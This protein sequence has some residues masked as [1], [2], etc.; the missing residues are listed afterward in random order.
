M[1]LLDVLSRKLQD[2][3]YKYQNLGLVVAHFDHGIRYESGEDYELVKQIAEKHGLE[4]VSESGKLGTNTSEAEARNA[5]YDFL[6]RVMKDNKAKGIIT[7]HHQDDVLETVIHNLLRGTGRLGL[8][9]LRSRE[10]ILRPLLGVTKSEIR[11]YAVK[12]QIIWHEDRTNADVKYR[13][14]YIRHQFLPKMTDRQ[15]ADFLRFVE[16]QEGLSTEIDSI[17][18]ALFDEQLDSH[19]KVSRSWFIMLPHIVAREVMASWLRRRGVTQLSRSLL[20]RLVVVAKTYANGRQT[21]IDKSHVLRINGDKLA[22]DAR[23]V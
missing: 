5:R 8:I 13:R 17:L 6:H 18:N 2:S 1:V 16:V 9:A 20:E 19:G 11:E 4:F 22:I 14:N 21:D 3:K 15:K 7:A 10:N 23:I 12:H